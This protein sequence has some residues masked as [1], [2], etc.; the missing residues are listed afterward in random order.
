M[1]GERAYVLLNGKR[2]TRR[3]IELM[4]AV[5][6]H[7]DRSLLQSV[8]WNAVAAQMGHAERRVSRDTFSRSCDRRGLPS[9][10]AALVVLG[11]AELGTVLKPEELA[12]LETLVH[13][14]MTK[15]CPRY[16][17]D[18]RRRNPSKKMLVG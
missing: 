3:Q 6:R 5:L 1:P 7:A 8:D 12:L 18:G 9:Q 16:L 10:K 14:W 13:R 2:L 17:L 11:A 4:V 15:Y